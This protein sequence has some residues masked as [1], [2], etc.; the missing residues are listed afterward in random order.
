M[1]AARRFNDTVEQLR[2]GRG[3]ERL[4]RRVLGLP[5]KAPQAPTW[6]ESGEREKLRRRR[7]AWHAE[8]RRADIAH[9]VALL[10]IT[11]GRLKDR[12]LREIEIARG[13]RALASA[14]TLRYTSIY[15]LPTR[16][17][18]DIDGYF[19]F[20]RRSSFGLSLVAA[21]AVNDS[22]LGAWQEDDPL[23]DDGLRG[24]LGGRHV[25]I[26][27]DELT[28][29]LAIEALQRWY[30][31][32][33]KFKRRHWTHLTGGEPTIVLDLDWADVES[34]GLHMRLLR[35]RSAPPGSS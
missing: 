17:C 11:V 34:G 7:A 35:E 33:F 6:P 28:P 29:E 24:L 14:R 5:A 20:G 18:T 23:T 10:P 15:V 32:R 2:D 13:M 22:A 21:S 4:I 26:P 9:A 27:G 8:D 31:S 19:D 25:L 16:G 3:R 1:S 30:R 12:T